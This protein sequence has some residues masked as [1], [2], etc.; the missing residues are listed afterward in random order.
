MRLQYRLSNGNWIDCGDR[1]EEFLARCDMFGGL[2][3]REAVLSALAEGKTVRNDS[4]G[5]YSECRDGDVAD[6][7]MA[8]ITASRA[9][10][11][12]DTRPTLQCRSCGQTGK[13]G[14]YPFSTLPESGRCDDCV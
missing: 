14:A 13:S 10:A 1:T 3:S 2:E 11:A 4:E 9:T 8:K 5:W 6:A 7:K 12:A